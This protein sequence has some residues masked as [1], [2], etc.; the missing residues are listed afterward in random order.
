[1]QYFN[2]PDYI[3]TGAGNDP[4]VGVFRPITFQQPSQWTEILEQAGEDVNFLTLWYESS[5]AGVNADG[6]YAWIYGNGA[7]NNHLVHQ[8]KSYRYRAPRLGVAGGVAYPG[9]KDFYVEGGEGNLVPFDIPLDN[10]QT[11]D[12]VLDSAAMNASKIEFLQLA[13]FNDFGEG[14]MFEP[15]VETDFDYLKQIQQITG[16]S[17]SE[18]ELELVYRLYLARIE[19]SGNGPIQAMLNEVSSFLAMLEVNSALALL[20]TAAP[21]GDFNADGLVDE[22]DKTVWQNTFGA[23]TMLYDSSA[24]GNHNGTI[25]AADFTIRRNGLMGGGDGV[26]A[27]PEPSALLLTMLAAAVAIQHAPLARA[28]SHGGGFWAAGSRSPPN[29]YSMKR[30]RASS[31][32]A[33]PARLLKTYRLCRALR[34]QPFAFCASTR[35]FHAGRHRDG[36]MLSRT[37]N[38]QSCWRALGVTAAVAAGCRRRNRRVDFHGRSQSQIL[39]RPR[40]GNWPACRLGVNRLGCP[41]DD[42]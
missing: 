24:D 30:L 18:S 12:A 3:L 4:L 8:S 9:C 26:I 27:V 36:S 41:V 17:H 7:Q 42:C 6:E 19:Y 16:V 20:N 35:S 28:H 10:G 40:K 2:K 37:R 5:D 34:R 23:S 39:S 13:T 15:T 21:A 32:G 25:D 38:L 1:M 31:I 22:L 14:T 33:K 11:L 29:R